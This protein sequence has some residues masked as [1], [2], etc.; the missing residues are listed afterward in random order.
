MILQLAAGGGSYLLAL[1]LLRGI[2]PDVRL[3]F[4]HRRLLTISAKNSN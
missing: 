4:T 2:P 3:F 1:I